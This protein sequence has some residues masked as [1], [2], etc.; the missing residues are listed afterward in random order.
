MTP[1]MFHI[2]FFPDDFWHEDFWLE[3]GTGI[4][5]TSRNKRASAANV[6]WGPLYPYPT[7]VISSTND[8]MMAIGE[9]ALPPWKNPDSHESASEAYWNDFA[10]AYDGDVSTYAY[11]NAY[12]GEP[13][14][15][16]FS[17]PI[18]TDIFRINIAKYFGSQTHIEQGDIEVYCYYNGAWRGSLMSTEEDAWLPLE[19]EWTEWGVGYDDSPQLI[20]AIRILPV[21]PSPAL[22]RVWGIQL[23][24]LNNQ[25]PAAAMPKTGSNLVVNP[26]IKGSLI[27]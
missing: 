13:L 10:N 14:D 24:D 17:P 11:S 25:F 18:R 1:G 15:L 16:N 4:L 9:Y 23:S 21:T 20:S 26:L 19:N 22:Y 8:R 2:N 12:E 6:P 5:T 27:R 3:Y 7:R